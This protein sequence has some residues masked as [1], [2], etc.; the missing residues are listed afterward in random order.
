MKDLS[1]VVS[2]R[3]AAMGVN[4]IAKIETHAA[5][6][7]L[8]RWTYKKL[9]QDKFYILVDKYGKQKVYNWLLENQEKDN[10]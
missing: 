5:P 1:N 2:D 6:N 3:I 10:A 9:T 4:A 7:E 8:T